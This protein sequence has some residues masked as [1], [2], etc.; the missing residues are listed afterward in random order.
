MRY[1]TEP[2]TLFKA[3]LTTDGERWGEAIWISVDQKTGA[4]IADNQEG[5]FVGEARND[6]V[7][8]SGV[9]WGHKYKFILRDKHIWMKFPL[10]EV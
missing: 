1:E 3:H 10:E 5:E 6:A 4:S 7:M 9:K 8:G 2:K